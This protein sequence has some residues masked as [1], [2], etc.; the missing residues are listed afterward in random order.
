MQAKKQSLLNILTLLKKE[1]NSTHTLT[2]KQ[3]QEILERDYDQKLDRKAIKRNLDELIAMGYDIDYTEKTRQNAEP[4]QTDWYINSDFTDSELR[5]LIDSVTF[6]KNIPAAHAKE[7]TRKLE[8]LTS[9]HFKSNRSKIELLHETMPSNP[10]FL[11]MIDTI[12]EAIDKGQ[13]ISF[14]Y[15][16]M[17]IDKQAHP[18]L[19]DDG[20]T[21]KTYQLSPYLL[22]VANG[23]TYLIGK[24]T[25]HDAMTYY[26][27]NRMANVQI[28]ATEPAPPLR[29]IA[30]F[31]HGID[32]PKHF[33]E[34][35]YMFS[36]DSI[37]VTFLIP[38][39]MLT[40]VQ[41][42]FGHDISLSKTADERIAVKVLVN[43]TAMFYW[44]LQYSQSCEVT[45]PL[46][47]RE[48]L[49]ATFQEN[50]DKYSK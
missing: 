9:K 31:E 34:H 12:S 46:D 42:W 28:L 35:I 13:Q 18:R 16:D 15:Q 29:E 33:A 30:G 4:I 1:T 44:A 36:G 39:N 17:G 27:V 11:L 14:H 25:W 7:L 26:R 48:E 40:I 49:R 43:R 20:V 50:L 8:N 47:L 41:E 5:F 3:I 24:H 22:T 45:A 10:Q 23:Q 38:E 21:P 37:R 32:L 2:A 19:K 6:S